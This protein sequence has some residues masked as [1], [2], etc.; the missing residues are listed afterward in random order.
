MEADVCVRSIDPM[1][2]DVCVRNE[3]PSHAIQAG[4]DA[5]R[6]GCTV[7]TD[8]RMVQ[9]GISERLL[10]PLGGRVV[11]D[12]SD[13]AVYDLAHELGV[14]RSR[15][16]MRRNRE[17]IDGGIV[18]I[19]NAPTALLEV[20]RLV[21][22]ERVRPG[23]IIG[24]P[25]GF[26]NTVEAKEELLTLREVPYITAVGRKGGSSVAVAIV[27]ALL[28]LATDGQERQGAPS[29]WRVCRDEGAP[30]EWRVCRDEG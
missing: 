13:P 8:V 18:A 11:C 12:I 14:T 25:V 19:G 23:L 3:R 10:A 4:I 29:E 6:G 24:V 28:R 22:E 21:R 27:N 1:K 26:V 17:H 16:A 9:V 7:V 15:A 2:A 5:L 30:S 20:I